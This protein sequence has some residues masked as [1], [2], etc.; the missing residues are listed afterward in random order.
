ML[1]ELERPWGMLW[2]VQFLS[3][4][5][6]WRQRN[7]KLSEACGFHFHLFRLDCFRPVC[8]YYLSLCGSFRPALLISVKTP[9]GCCTMNR[10][11]GRLF[12]WPL[13]WDGPFTL[14]SHFHII[15]LS[16]LSFSRFFQYPSFI[17]RLLWSYGP[18]LLAPAYVT[19]NSPYFRLPLMTY[20]VANEVGTQFL[21]CCFCQPYLR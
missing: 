18:C 4:L 9:R 15:A 6:V 5:G 21:C 8:P 14:F 3:F 20:S 12:F 19:A 1:R 17:L 7:L 2:L 16:Y 11:I 13:Y 10:S